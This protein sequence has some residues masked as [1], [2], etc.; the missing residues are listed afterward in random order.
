MPTAIG[1]NAL[2]E[3]I[4]GE[5][6][7]ITLERGI[8]YEERFSDYICPKMSINE[9]R[10]KLKKFRDEHG[11]INTFEI[12]SALGCISL[13]EPDIF[14]EAMDDEYVIKIEDNKSKKIEEL[15]RFVDKED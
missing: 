1:I 4:K 13:P 12:P 2:K 9:I 7:L 14:I 5:K 10:E 3:I 6:M 11:E 8:I 15:Y